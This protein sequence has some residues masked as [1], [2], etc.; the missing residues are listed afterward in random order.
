[1]PVNTAFEPAQ[2]QPLWFLLQVQYN[3]LIWQTNQNTFA[4][5]IDC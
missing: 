2:S 4:H 3:L 5:G 1:M